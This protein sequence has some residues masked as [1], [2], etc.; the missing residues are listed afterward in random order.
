M[1]SSHDDSGGNDSVRVRAL[2]LTVHDMFECNVKYI[3]SCHIVRVRRLLKPEA[4]N[5]LTTA[6]NVIL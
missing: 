5:L 2:T 4:R 1:V 3:F 6:L